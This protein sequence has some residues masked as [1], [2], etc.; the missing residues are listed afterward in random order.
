[1]TETLDK[2]YADHEREDLYAAS[3]ARHAEKVEAERRAEWIRYHLEQAERLEDTAAALAQE[4][5]ERAE[6]L[7]QEGGYGRLKPR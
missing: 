7:R 3:C 2:S 5:R 4:H 1:M 6:R